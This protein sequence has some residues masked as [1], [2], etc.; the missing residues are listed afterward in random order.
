MRDYSKHETEDQRPEPKQSSCV[1]PRRPHWR[2]E[3][4]EIWKKAADLAVKFH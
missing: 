3:D 2:F 1:P 4:L